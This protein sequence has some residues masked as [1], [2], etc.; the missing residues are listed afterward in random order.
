MSKD[1]NDDTVVEIGSGTPYGTTGGG[2]GSNYD[3]RERLARLEERVNHLASKEDIQK[4]KIWV[5]GGVI[6]AAVF[7]V[8]IASFIFR[9]V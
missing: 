5:L 9:F 8:S 3:I 6:G 4:L 7:A 1:K 2:N